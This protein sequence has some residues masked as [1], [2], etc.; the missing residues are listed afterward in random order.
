V[1]DLSGPVALSL[2]VFDGVHRG[3]QAVLELL[4]AE[5]GRR[6]ASPLVASLDPHPLA[7]LRPEK[8]P[9]LLTPPAERRRLLERFAPGRAVIWPFDQA[10]AALS[11]EEFLGQLLP[12]QASLAVLV[13]GHD[14]RMGRDRSGGFEEL[15][16]LG[17][18]RG[19]DVARASQVFVRGEPVSS[20]RIRDLVTEGNVK[21]A[22]E[23]LGH[24]Y[25]LE[26]PVVRGR[27]I[28]RTLDFPTANADVEDK[29]KVLPKFGVYAVLV[30]I[31]T[32]GAFEA[33]RPGVMNVGVRPTFGGG[34]PSVEVHLPDFEGDLLGKRL[35]IELVDRIREERSFDGPASLAARIEEDVRLARRILDDALAAGA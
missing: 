35:F 33:P 16:A 19:F 32:S 21:E 1:A 20:S 4:R 17:K 5:A 22:A 10:T 26:G 34:D 23:L 14:F 18:A 12:P 9:Q 31:V 2:G 24:R 28:G 8:A 3:H 30:R 11:A 7:V 27:G 6:R 13:V 25:S 29:R 15:T